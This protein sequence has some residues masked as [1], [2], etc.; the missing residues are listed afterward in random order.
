MSEESLKSKALRAAIKVM[1]S[2]TA[3]RVMTDER[4][5]KA[6]NSA[7]RFG[8]QVRD[9]VREARGQIAERLGGA[10]DDDLR[11]MKRELDRLQRQVAK[12]KKEAKARDDDGEN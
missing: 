2:D 8:S 10:P 4:F 9:G 3:Q 7:M 6:V 12:L 5:Q 11:E 1:Q